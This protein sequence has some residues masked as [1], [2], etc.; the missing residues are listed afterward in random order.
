MK[1]LNSFRNGMQFIHM[2]NL[3]FRNYGLTSQTEDVL[4]QNLE[5]QFIPRLDASGESQDLSTERVLRGTEI[6]QGREKSHSK[7]QKGIN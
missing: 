5:K 4:R 1:L 6:G 2:L 7:L 3:P